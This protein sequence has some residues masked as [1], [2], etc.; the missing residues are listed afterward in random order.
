MLPFIEFSS[1]GE[2]MK[3]GFHLISGHMHFVKQ[4][5]VQTGFELTRQLAALPELEQRCRL[6]DST[7]NQAN[8]TT[9]QKITMD[10][11]LSIPKCVW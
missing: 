10:E 4:M 1:Q 2:S 6:P 11:D 9:L 7:L 3:K 8:K 5:Q